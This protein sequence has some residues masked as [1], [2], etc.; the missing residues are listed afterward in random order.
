MSEVP[1]GK[2]IEFNLQPRDP[3]RKTDT[4]FVCNKDDIFTHRKEK[5]GEIKWFPA[6]RKYSFFPVEGC[7]FEKTCLTDI[8]NFLDW[9]MQER[10][11]GK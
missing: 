1:K 2:W 11:K 5:L 6:F 8:C 7:I 3:K 10:N 4:Y 9:L